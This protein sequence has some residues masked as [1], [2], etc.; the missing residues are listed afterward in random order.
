[1][2]IQESNLL[3]EINRLTINGA[4]VVSFRTYGPGRKIL[5]STTLEFA[6]AFCGESFF[7][8]LSVLK[9]IRYSRSLWAVR[10]HF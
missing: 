9:N 3:L 6:T 1:M 8:S 5:V 4:Q 2:N 7:L 10:R